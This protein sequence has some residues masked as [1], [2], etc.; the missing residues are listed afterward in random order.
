MAAGVYWGSTLCHTAQNQRELG[1]GETNSKTSNLRAKHFLF[2]LLL[3]HL[4]IEVKTPSAFLTKENLKYGAH[5]DLL[6][7]F[8]PLP[9][10]QSAVST[11]HGLLM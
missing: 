1:R 7:M 3:S 10:I 8:C 5:F 4:S 2:F 6:C 9:I 11:K